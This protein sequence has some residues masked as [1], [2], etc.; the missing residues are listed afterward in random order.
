MH[1][2]GSAA[3]GHPPS[4][5]LT[6]LF[7]QPACACSS[8]ADLKVNTHQAEEEEVHFCF[9]SHSSACLVLFLTAFQHVG[10]FGFSLGVCDLSFDAVLFCRASEFYSLVREFVPIGFHFFFPWAMMI[11]ISP[12]LAEMFFCGLPPLSKR[13]KGE[14]FSSVYGQ[15]MD[16]PSMTLLRGYL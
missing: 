10:R 4:L 2:Y 15:G 6:G 9:S 13:N 12:L 5:G 1:G 8:E 14:V 3:L 16:C 7:E 11:F